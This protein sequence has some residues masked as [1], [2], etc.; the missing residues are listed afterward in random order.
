MG[1]RIELISKIYSTQ[2]RP[3]MLETHLEIDSSR[4]VVLCGF[5]E[6]CHV[7]FNQRSM[8]GAIFSM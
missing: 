5:G 1:V 4:C 7:L 6:S 2:P 3:R 8:F